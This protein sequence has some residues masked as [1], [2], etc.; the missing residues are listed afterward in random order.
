[1]R[2]VQRLLILSGLVVVIL[3]AWTAVPTGSWVP[4]RSTVLAQ[5]SCSAGGN[6]CSCDLQGCL[7]DCGTSPAGC[8]C[9]CTKDKG[10]KPVLE[11]VGDATQTRL[12]AAILPG[13][14]RPIRLPLKTSS[15]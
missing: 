6:N 9:S 1:M 12:G 14:A 15:I 5:G 8:Y 2:C 7:C 11:P 13:S 3:C 4:A 10:P